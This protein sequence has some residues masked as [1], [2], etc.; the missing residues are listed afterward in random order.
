MS[1]DLLRLECLE[2]ARSRR[3]L[4]FRH[5]EEAVLLRRCEEPF[6][7]VIARSRSS[8]SLQGAVLLR[9]CEEPKATKQSN[10]QPPALFFSMFSFICFLISFFFAWYFLN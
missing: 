10:H 2:I 5:C 6:L 9:H 1:P 4:F 8:S 7:F 3:R